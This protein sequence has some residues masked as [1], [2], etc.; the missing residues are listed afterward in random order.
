MAQGIA[1][2]SQGKVRRRKLRYRPLFWAG[3]MLPALVWTGLYAGAAAPLREPLARR[4]SAA[5]D[6][7]VTIG[8]PLRILVTPF[9]I[10]L[11]ANDVRIA[12][13]GWAQAPEMLRAARLEAR[14]DTFDLML[15][16]PALRGLALRDGTLDLERSADGRKASWT[17]GKDGS[18]TDLTAVRALSADGLHVRY[19][20][21]AKASETRFTMNAARDGTTRIDGQGQAGTHSF[22]FSGALGATDADRTRLTLDA[23][24]EGLTLGIEARADSPF[25]L[26]RARLALDAQGSDFARLAALAGIAL[27]AMPD[28]AMRAELRRSPGLWRFRAVEGRIG[29]T[30][31]D[32]QLLLD[33]RKAR[34]RLVAE[35]ASR[36]LDVGDVRALAGFQPATY[37]PED[38]A[39]GRAAPRLLPDAVLSP[40]A[41]RQFDARIAYTA[42][43]V[44]GL[45]HAPAHL[46]F[47]LDLKQGL[48]RLSPAS[49]D[50]DGGF[51]SSDIMIDGRQD[52]VLARYD[53]RLSPTPMGRLLAGW[54][55]A[56]RG[57]TTTLRGRVELAGRGRTIRETLA[58]AGGRIALVIPRGAVSARRASTGPLDIANLNAALFPAGSGAM[59]DI[60][61]GLIAFTVQDGV[62][63]ADPIL[64]D[65]RGHVLSGEGRIDLRNETIDLRLEADGKQFALFGRPHPVILAGSFASPTV[66]REPIA[67]FRPASLFGF[68]FGLPNVSALFDFVDP[69]EARAP[70]CGP[71]LSGAPGAAQLWASAD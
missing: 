62:A 53:I 26:D 47:K 31:L 65:T 33:L 42:D 71:M 66:T 18:L 10:R 54:G 22:A 70:Q 6:R 36:S 52:P 23:R 51:V 13:P 21:P 45:P 60:N 55:V 64:I 20:D 34:P 56:E 43:S 39:F 49:V 8:G 58:N 44:A 24:G 38:D 27:P 9:S 57:T 40:A 69:G 25:T 37:A 30:D 12:N 19:R 15:G 17:M 14:F 63:T 11:I 7:D 1:Q 4:A 28:Y 32:G 2:V 3:L 5:L 61:C 16:Q 46:S 29:R 59:S 68:S 50:L 35:L 48:L 67:W 41:L